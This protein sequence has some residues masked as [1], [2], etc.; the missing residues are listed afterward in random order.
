M[1]KRRISSGSERQSDVFVNPELNS[2]NN[3]AGEVSRAFG[4]G[5]NSAAK[6]ANAVRS[7]L[8]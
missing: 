5:K 8:G 4:N 2:V 7:R 6:R 3:V 1:S